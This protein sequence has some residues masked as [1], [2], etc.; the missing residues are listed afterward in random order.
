MVPLEQRVRQE[1]VEKRVLLVKEV[2]RV[3]RVLPEEQA[4]RDQQDKLAQLALKVN[5]DSQEV[6][7]LQVQQDPVVQRDLEVLLE[8]RVQMVSKGPLV[9]P[10]LLAL[11]ALWGLQD[12]PELLVSRVLKVLQ[13][14]KDLEVYKGLLVQRVRL[15]QW[16]QVELRVLQA[17]RALSELQVPQDYLAKKAL[18]VIQAVQ[19]PKVHKA[20]KELLDFKD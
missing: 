7:D 20:H 2:S 18:E 10:V 5:R 12:L 17:S 3:S 4:Y 19:D 8:H 16:G 9:L 15:A 14:F 13:V 1:L 11:L 6:L